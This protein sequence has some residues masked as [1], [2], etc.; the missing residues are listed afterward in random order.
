MKYLTTLVMLALCAQATFAET[1]Y[2]GRDATGKTIYSDQPIQNGHAIDVQPVQTFQTPTIPAKLS[3]NKN[4]TQKLPTKYS[5]EITE[6]Q[7]EQVFPHA[8]NV[9]NV[10]VSITPELEPDDRIRLLLNNEPYGALSQ[11]PNFQLTQL[12]RGAYQVQAVIVGSNGQGSK[13]QSGTITFYQQRATIKG[14]TA[15]V[16]KT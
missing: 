5:L 6:P 1:V 8:V 4:D 16:P 9:I 2:K 3:E 13:G 15:P 10:K 12:S 7:N 11:S 14:P